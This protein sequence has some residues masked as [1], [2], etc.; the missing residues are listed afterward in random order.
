MHLSTKLLAILG[1]ANV[2]ADAAAIG[3]RDAAF[4]EVR[5][6]QTKDMS[7][8]GGDPKEKYFRKSSSLSCWVERFTDYGTDE[9]V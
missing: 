9:S 5:T 7:G 6:K 8:R 4:L 3:K 2:F 1:V